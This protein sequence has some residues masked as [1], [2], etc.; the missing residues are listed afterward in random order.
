[1]NIQI[2][3]KRAYCRPAVIGRAPTDD[4]ASTLGVA[5]K[6]QPDPEAP[7]GHAQSRRQ[8]PVRSGRLNVAVT[9][10]TND[11]GLGQPSSQQQMTGNRTLINGGSWTLAD[12]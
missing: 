11:Y 6:L 5:G 9:A 1:M 10:R 2:M 8:L 3:R 7:F 12:Q 4:V